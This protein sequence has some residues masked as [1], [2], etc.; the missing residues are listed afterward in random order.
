MANPPNGFTVEPEPDNN[1]LTMRVRSVVLDSPDAL[2][3][4]LPAI[5]AGFQA[6]AWQPCF[7]LI[8][9]T[10]LRI[11][12]RVRTYLQAQGQLTEA[13]IRALIVFSPQPDPVT[14]LLL[15]AGSGYSNIPYVLAAD[16]ATAR[17]E[18]ARLQA[19]E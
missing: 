1:I 5:L 4:V 6:M 13:L 12:P 2:D 9:I 15:R 10:G 14:E 7:V 19:N 17:A 3:A 16:E 18:I 8:D 11:A